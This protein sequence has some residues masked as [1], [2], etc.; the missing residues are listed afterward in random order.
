M[1]TFKI[2]ENSRQA[3]I[4]LEYI[5]TLSFVEILSTNDVSTKKE[6][7][8]LADIERGL[9]EVK[10]IREGKIEPLSTNELWHD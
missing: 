6:K 4:F 3:R 5:K 8:L 7:A 2:K 9:R 1:V 10:D